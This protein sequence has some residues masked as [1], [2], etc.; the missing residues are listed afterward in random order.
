[1]SPAL[2]WT[3]SPE[4]IAQHHSRPGGKTEVTIIFV[5]HYT[6]EIMDVFPNCLL[7]KNGRIYAKD[8]TDK[9]FTSEELSKFLNYPVT[10]T[11]QNQRIN[12]SLEVDSHMKELM[13]RV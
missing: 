12:V 2:V 5:T 6:E 10:V 1:M 7:L 3:F 8:R 11:W 13:E 4:N 9:L